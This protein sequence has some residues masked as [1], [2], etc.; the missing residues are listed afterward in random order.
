MFD[1]LPQYP[2]TGILQLPMQI[3]QGRSA[4]SDLPISNTARKQLEIQPE[5]LSNI[6]KHVKLSTIDLHVGQHVVYQERV[7]K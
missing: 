2:P 5:M 3:V 1:D 4:R 7:S 6:D